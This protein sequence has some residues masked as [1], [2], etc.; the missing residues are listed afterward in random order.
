MRTPKGDP[1]SLARTHI[2]RVYPPLSLSLFHI[3]DLVLRVAVINKKWFVGS[4]VK[5]FSRLVVRCFRRRPLIYNRLSR[6][7]GRQVARWGVHYCFRTLLQLIRDARLRYIFLRKL[8]PGAHVRC[9]PSAR[10]LLKFLRGRLQ[11]SSS[12]RMFGMSCQQASSLRLTLNTLTFSLA[13]S[14]K[15]HSDRNSATRPATL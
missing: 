11:V 1:L 4:A 5:L 6:L 10:Q 14:E 8:S 7:L 15:L 13:L 12:E 3:T 9:A 2:L